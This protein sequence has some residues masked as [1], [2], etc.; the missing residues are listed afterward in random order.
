MKL[1]HA[2]ALALVGWYLMLLPAHGEGPQIFDLPW[3]TEVRSFDSAKE[4]EEARAKAVITPVPLNSQS[5]VAG[6]TPTPTP[7]NRA[8][9]C[10]EADDPRLKAQDFH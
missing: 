10:I 8:F 3:S 1:R 4:C 7:V 9:Y 2:A 6:P 5:Q